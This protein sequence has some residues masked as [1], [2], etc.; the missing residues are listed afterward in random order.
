MAQLTVTQRVEVYEE[1]KRKGV[2][3]ILEQMKPDG[4][5]GPMEE[6]FYHYRLPWTFTV[7]GE[8]KAALKVC[9]WV[10]E[11]MLT[12]EGDFD[13]GWRVGTDAYAYKNGTFIYGAHMARQYDLSYGCM[14]FL[15][16]LQDPVSG[17]FAN[18]VT[19]EGP[20]DTMDVPYT[21]GAGLAC[22]A[23]GHLDEA[24]KVHG[25]L[26]K[27]YGQQDELPDRFY[28]NLS[29][30][31]QQVVR[32]FAPDDRFWNVVVAQEPIKQR[33]T[34]GGIASAFLSRLYMAD[35]RPEY[36]E[37]ARKYIKFS[38]D[39]T[40][41][42]F[43]F[44]ARVQ[45]WVGLVAALP[46]HRGRPVPGLDLQDGRLVHRYPVRGRQL[47]GWV[48]GVRRAAVEPDPSDCR[49]RRP[50]RQHHRRALVEGVMKDTLT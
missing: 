12:P 25:Y 26:V 19:A 4:S 7:A 40:D 14:P 9:A 28:Y 17:G 20:G 47:G 43:E 34:V 22:I 1:T 27:V 24:R 36:I 49:V 50:R 13:R 46:G 45:V 16:S 31:T 39:S 33:W 2:E 3:F 37:L 38:M 30:A 18:D 29:R 42:Q 32:E 5:V 11:N 41:G 35:P 48:R 21:I 8:N 10:R 6:G 15:L 44:A 23:T